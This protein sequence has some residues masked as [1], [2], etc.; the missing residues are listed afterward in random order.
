M[1]ALRRVLG[2]GTSL[3]NITVDPEEKDDGMEPPQKPVR[4][5]SSV[6]PRTAAT[7][8]Q[9]RIWALVKKNI[10]RFAQERRDL[11]AKNAEYCKL[12]ILDAFQGRLSNGLA[13][14]SKKSWWIYTIFCVQ[15]SEVLFKC[16]M[17]ACVFHTVSLFFEPNNACADSAIYT[18]LQVLVLLIYSFDIALKMSYEGIEVSC[19][20]CIFGLLNCTRS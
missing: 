4:R 10:P 7:E 3:K 20:Q 13:N 1:N 8:K 14:N 9:K 6:T 2:R 18:A 15:T 17:G 16:V 19:L 11:F 12:C 5:R